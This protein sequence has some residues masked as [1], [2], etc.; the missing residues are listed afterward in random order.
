VYKSKKK[1]I[2]YSLN[3]VLLNKYLEVIILSQE[4]K[5]LNETVEVLFFKIKKERIKPQLSHLICKVP[6]LV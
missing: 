1:I 6:G 2:T 5:I 4:P 3:Y